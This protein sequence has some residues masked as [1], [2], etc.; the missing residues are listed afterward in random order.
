MASDIIQRAT[1]YWSAKR[2]GARL[3]SRPDINTADLADVLENI[4]VAEAIDGGRDYMHRLA[5][6]RAEALMGADMQG[7]R[8]SGIDKGR[9]SLAAWRNALN[10]SRTLRAPHFA[11]IE[12]DEESG[13]S[14]KAVFLPLSR[15]RGVEAADFVLSVL[16]ES[17]EWPKN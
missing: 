9:S 15:G 3:P 11:T 14:V 8:L 12:T 16:T 10:L 1:A 6:A 7:A 2:R 17:R 5:G 13:R 4:V